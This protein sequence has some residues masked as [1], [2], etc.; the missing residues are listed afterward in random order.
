MSSRLAVQHGTRVP[1][2]ALPLLAV[3]CL[4]A[5]PLPATAQ[6]P[7]ENINMVSGTQWP[8]GDPF[9]QRQ[10]EPSIAVSSANPLHLLAGANDY[11]SVD[12]SLAVTKMTGDAWLGVFKSFD[13]GQTWRSV[14]L[15]GHPLD[16]SPEGQV[17]P[18]KGFT[19][20]ADPLVRAGPGGMLYYSGITFNRNAEGSQVFVA[21]FL[22]RND[23]ENGDAAQGRDPIQYLDTSVVD[24][25][26]KGTFIDKPWLAV[27][28]P[29]P[30]ATCTL[31]GQPARTVPAAPLYLVYSIFIGPAEAASVI[32]FARSTDCGHTWSRPQIVSWGSILNNG[33][34]VAVDPVSDRLIIAW[35]R[36]AAFGQGDALVAVRS[37][38]ALDGDLD[39]FSLP[40][41][42]ASIVPFDQDL[43]P[44]RFRSEGL[45]ALAVSVDAAGTHSWAHLAWTQRASPGA[46]GRV[47]LSSSADGAH[48]SAPVPADAG[49]VADD[50]GNQFTRGHQLMPALTFSQGRLMLLYYDSRL[51]H[52][53]GYFR[54]NQPFLP[55]P[56]GRFYTEYRAPR[57]ELVWAPDLVHGPDLD[58]APLSDT[59]HTLEVRV[60]QASPGPAPVFATARVSQFR[61]G[62]RGDEVVN[63]QAPGFGPPLQV[64]DGQGN[65]QL[66]QQLQVNPPGLPIFKN[67]TVPFMGDYIDIAGPAFVPTPGGGWAFNTAPNPAPVHYAVWTSNQD[68]RPP[69]DGDWTHYTP[70]GVAGPSFFDPTVNRPAC[71]TG[72][73]GM[74]N[75]NIY[76]ARITDGLLVTSPQNAKPLSSTLTRAFVVAVANATDRERAVRFSVTAPA[77]VA[78]SF[79][80]DGV[81]L[82]TFDVAIPARSSIAR[83]LFVRLAGSADPAATLVVAAAEVLDD[84]A[85]LGALPP[86]CPT[87][88]G[89][90]AG[91]VTLNPPGTTPVLLQPDGSGVD[92]TSLEVYPPTASAA[93]VT[94]A[95]VTS[96]SLPGAANVTS[97][98]V[99]SANVTSANVTSTHVAN[100]DLANVTSA[101]VTSANVTSAN[102]TSANV[103]SSALAN[104][105]VTSA[106]VTSAN[107][108]SAAISDATYVV[109]NAGNTA[110]SYHVAIV[111]TLPAGTPLQL[112]LS[113]PYTTP[114]A[115]GC[116]L[117][118]EPRAVVVANIQDVSAAVVPAGG[119][120][121]DPN[122]PDARP[123]NA[124][125]SLAPGETMQVTVRGVLTTA[126]MTALTTQLAP[127]VV[128]HAGG[129]YAAPLLVTSD[130]GAL[131]L[132]RVGVPY[133]ASLL[134][135]GGT[136][137]YAWSLAPGS[138]PLPAGLTLGPDG[139]LS[140]TPTGA[141][142][143]TF[144]A[145]VT[146]SAAAPASAPRA[147]TLTVASGPTSAVLGAAPAPSMAFQ[148]VELTA[149]VSPGSSGPG[150]PL[151][152]GPVTFLDGTVPL[153][154]ATLQGGSA[155][156]TVGTLG[157]GS[158]VLSASFAGDGNYLGSTSAPLAH[159]V[160]QG[161]TTVGLAASPVLPVYGQPLTLTASVARSP[162][163]TGAPS[164]SGT[165]TF[166]DGP[167][168]LGQA[169][170]SAGQA[171]L[172]VSGLDTGG[173]ALVARYGGD[174]ASVASTSTTVP[175][176][177]DLAPTA[178]ALDAAPN[179][180]LAGQ[181]VTLTATVS[182]PPPG[183]GVVA[184]TVT[185]L[186]GA[187]PLG[188]VVLAGGTAS[189]STAD[190]GVGPHALTARY[191]GGGG[192]AGSS[193]APVS[194]PVTLG[195]TA[196][197]LSA[198]PALPVFGQPLTLTASV[199]RGQTWPGA[200]TPA[201]IVTFSDGAVP[202]G[203]AVLSAGVATL[204]VTSLGTGGHALVA[205]YGG[206]AFSAGSTSA[207]TPL[208]VDLAATATA[209]SAAPNPSLAGQAVTL[210]ATV[211]VPPPGA[212]VVAGAVTFLDGATVLGTGVLSASGVATFGTSALA[213]ATHSI[214]ARFAGGGGLA[215]S[216]SAAVS[217][218]VKSASYAF[219]G[220]LS[221]LSTAGTLSSPTISSPQTCGSVLPVKWQL[222]DGSGA[223]VTRL[224]SAT[225]LKAL[226]NPA[227]K[228]AAP[229]N[230]KA[231]V[232]YSAAAGA[233]GANQFRYDAVGH[234]FILSWS[235]SK[236]TDKGCWELVLQL[237]DGSPA[238]ATIVKLQ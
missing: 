118:E 2:G 173:H 205:S 87:V 68:V 9:L 72:Q 86:T 77:G 138:G 110:H 133:L 182:V 55:D 96:P 41:V 183:A 79:R 166:F 210:T 176:V 18:L 90:L 84:P 146:D 169:V 44:T 67:G 137:P 226:Q 65:V 95:N 19:A 154:T 10:N 170:L 129:A 50:F 161:S 1:A 225:S 81:A 124:S 160:T 45:P 56:L 187:T 28:R 104:A 105:N 213:V 228:G 92:V 140:G 73:E 180:S 135:L 49:P 76:S 80:N 179:P 214:T 194:Q 75:Q 238:R 237:D 123:T 74:R 130:G 221:P 78:A 33:A 109:T 117:V 181:A 7:G 15:P 70:V 40:T 220:F 11:R 116:Q 108:T 6:I 204:V 99:T 218:V 122:I 34:V 230:A 197:S 127:V 63:Q 53:R 39:D 91:S 159:L 193:S 229:A 143:S 64:V 232:L 211:T 174:D 112:I 101:N 47:V 60:G 202:L 163:W 5:A 98:N 162:T 185:F 227:C 178:T 12:L 51:S 35:R 191:G 3:F 216:T 125:F 168:P 199:A 224:T 192:L 31:P 94:S 4:L 36:F 147:L 236:L 203:Q 61:F 201:G 206:D 58:D 97:A 66:L 93:N 24:V 231:V 212:G 208:V 62:T 8:G 217:Q 114:L 235:T 209:L 190:L 83:S 198:S 136:P 14:L 158:H 106:N 100:P 32:M 85:C 134:A 148:P 200:P 54:P 152:A 103:T 23:K 27:G 215:A 153:G 111:G 102:V 17:S 26:L 149:S 57:G 48:W 165:V 155:R 145:Q 142:T 195:T 172:V 126:A 139:T 113:K 46:D 119:L 16:A 196:V 184:G 89:G 121:T 189:L 69:A 156:L 71:V 43:T 88:P 82:Q 52:T 188:T 38:A 141:G 150:V 131:P 222:K 186:D 107:V 175:L 171:T 157:V 151:P 37:T 177:V 25:G 120:L 21:R 132:P 22:D 20:A 13:G 164:P 207:T 219:T 233:Q 115:L 144:T 223:W 167:A 234:Q 42:V 29:Q 59:R 30:G 128:A